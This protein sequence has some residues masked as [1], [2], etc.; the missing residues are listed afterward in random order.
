M[1]S[2]AKRATA[3]AIFALIATAANI[4]AQDAAVR[5]YDGVF[6]VQLSIAAGTAVGL[7]IKYFLDKR[8]IFRFTPRDIAHDGRVFAFYALT[9]VATTAVFWG[10]E[11]AFHYFFRTKEMRYFGGIIGLALG[12][13]GKYQLDRRYV[14]QMEGK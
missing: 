9:G 8:Y 1:D 10:V 12:Y 6:A 7:T 14:F 13:L 2:S 11:L 3:Y 4:A 5:W